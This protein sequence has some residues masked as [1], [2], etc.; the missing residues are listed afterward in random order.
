MY[1][2]THIP[3]L[4]D[5]LVLPGEV[6]K[7][8]IDDLG[9]TQADLAMKSGLAKKT[10]NEIIK[11]KASITP[12]TALKFELVLGRPAQFWSN[13]EM[14]Y[15]EDKA[16]LEERERLKL[17]IEWLKH[18]PVNAMIKNGWIERYKDKVDQLV[19]VLKFYGVASRKQ[20]E[21][22]WIGNKVAFR[23]TKQW[24]SCREAVSAWLREGE[25][26]ARKLECASFDG[27]RFKAILEEVR[28]LSSL[29]PLEFEPRLIGLCASAGVAVVFIPELPRTLTYGAT[30]WLGDRALIQLSLRHKNNDHLWFTFFHEAGHIVLHGRKDIFI[31]TTGLDDAKEKEADEF[32]RNMLIPPDR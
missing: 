2:V 4:P 23:H 25:R 14:R 31:E 17:D 20:W 10:I 29:S 7:D 12:E 11:G 19:E 6:L 18:V 8:Y 26:Q 27:K 9:M 22:V 3:Y 24:E 30:R 13:L 16:R 21:A 1:N 15:Q 32:A 28:I 5:Y